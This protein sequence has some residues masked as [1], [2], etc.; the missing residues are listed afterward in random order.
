MGLKDPLKTGVRAQRIS[1]V[2]QK[3]DVDFDRRVT[4]TRVALETMFGAASVRSTSTIRVGC[5]YK[6]SKECSIDAN[7]MAALRCVDP[8]LQFEYVQNDHWCVRVFRRGA[9][10]SQDELSLASKRR[11]RA[12]L[13]IQALLCY[14]A[15][16][17][18]VP[19]R[20]G[21]CAYALARFAKLC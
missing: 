2:E 21:A 4:H 5:V 6:L 18:L 14:G 3:S 1:N 13:V 7:S 20:Y 19:T 15:L 9:V 12:F 11:L 16:Y 17:W 8:N 10:T